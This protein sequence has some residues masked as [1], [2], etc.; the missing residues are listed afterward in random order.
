MSIFDFLWQRRGEF[1]VEEEMLYHYT[2]LETLERFL[3]DEG[4]FYCTNP[5]ML[6][7]DSELILGL[8][9]AMR[10]FK[11]MYGWTKECVERFKLGYRKC[12]DDGSVV[13]PWIM[14]FSRAGDSLS[15]WGM[16][17][18]RKEGGVA[19]G[20]RRDNLWGAI[21]RLPGR[22]SK[23]ASDSASS[24]GFELRLLP[25]LYTKSDEKLI[26]ELFE[27]RSEEYQDA[28]RRLG[29]FSFHGDYDLKDLNMVVATIMEIS[30][31]VKHESFKQEKEERLIL[32]PK[33]HS[34][35]DCKILGGKVRWQTYI[36]EAQKEGIGNIKYKALRG[37][38]REVKISPHGDTRRLWQ[39][40]KF[41]LKRHNM[42]YCELKC[43][44]LPYNGR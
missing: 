30:V 27:L 20:L 14:S 41:L 26:R 31:L 19:V 33:T 43:S 13:I 36:R 37:L 23:I 11:E 7:D 15:Q 42:D 1:F 21:D 38:F 6:N 10:Y 17:T 32:L 39:M 24:R 16:Y 28:F 2:T 44:E 3:E 12:I 29:R 34:L 18:D 5:L 40:V 25:C 4:D 8:D 35:Q 9:I 22:Y